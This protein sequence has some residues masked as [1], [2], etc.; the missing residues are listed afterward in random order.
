MSFQHSLTNL[1]SDQKQNPVLFILFGA[2]NLARSYYGLILSIKRCIH[3]RKATFISCY[4]PR[5]EDTSVEVEYSTRPIHPLLIVAFLNLYKKL[6]KPNQ[7]IIAL[8]TDIGNDIMYG[9]HSEKI[10]AGLQKIL[11]TLGE[12]TKKY[13]YHPN[14]NKLKK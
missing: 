6:R 14:S 13:F 3:P 1:N 2:S 12:F 5:E 4:G 11:D 8:I 9:I 10:I 7:Q